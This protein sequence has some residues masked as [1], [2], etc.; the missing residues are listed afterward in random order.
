MVMEVVSARW[1]RRCLDNRISISGFQRV[2][3]LELTFRLLS[4]CLNL[5][6]RT[7]FR[8]T[9]HSHHIVAPLESGSP[10]RY[11]VDGVVLASSAHQLMSTFSSHIYVVA[12]ELPFLAQFSLAPVELLHAMLLR[13]RNSFAVR[14]KTRISA[15]RRESIRLFYLFDD[16]PVRMLGRKSFTAFQSSFP[17]DVHDRSS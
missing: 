9:L 10:T 3:A 12:A 1:R 6:L 8:Q 7:T 16:S 11:Y 15:V 4:K 13:P 14:Q 17:S 5:D 2:S